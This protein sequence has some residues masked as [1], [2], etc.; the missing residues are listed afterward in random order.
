MGTHKSKLEIHKSHL[1]KAIFL[2]IKAKVGKFCKSNPHPLFR[3]IC[4]FLFFILQKNFI[5]AFIFIPAVKSRRGPAK[6]EQAAGLLLVQMLLFQTTFNHT[7]NHVIEAGVILPGNFLDLLNDV[8]PQ[9]DGFIPC[10]N[11]FLRFLGDKRHTHHLTGNI[12]MYL[13]CLSYIRNLPCNFC[14]AVI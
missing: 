9:I 6:K 14:K 2:Y 7:D 10:L 11:L 13:T 12:L 5:S 1:Y 4:S 8:L 3:P